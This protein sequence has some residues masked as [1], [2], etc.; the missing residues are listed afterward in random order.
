MA[1]AAAKK[2]SRARISQFCHQC[3]PD[4]ASSGNPKYAGQ[5]A[6]KR[7]CNPDTG[8][9]G[10]MHIGRRETYFFSEKCV[11]LFPL[12]VYIYIEILVSGNKQLKRPFDPN[13]PLNCS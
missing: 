2:P 4:V 6:N 13:D 8:F 10:Y 7:V 1:K 9:R 12:Y 3:N 11:C 5:S